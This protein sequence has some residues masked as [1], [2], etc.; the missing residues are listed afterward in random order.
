MRVALI[1]VAIVATGAAIAGS[2]EASGYGLQVAINPANP[3]IGDHVGVAVSGLMPYPCDTVTESHSVVGANLYVRLAYHRFT[4]PACSTVL[5]DF[6][7]SA[8]LGRLS[9]GHYHLT[10]SAEQPLGFCQSSASTP[11]DLIPEDCVAEQDLVVTGLR[12]LPAGGG[13][14]GNQSRASIPVGLGATLAFAGAGTVF[15]S[16]RRRK[17]QTCTR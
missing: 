13:P 8:D 12:G 15:G 3:T 10:V 2:A 1:A 11:S 14:L 7:I 4:V 6:T 5:G 16:V 17:D 9:A